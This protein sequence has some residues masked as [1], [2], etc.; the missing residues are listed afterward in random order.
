M[1]KTSRNM[2]IAAVVI[3]ALVIIGFVINTAKNKTND[4]SGTYYLENATEKQNIERLMSV[5]L[6]TDGSALLATPP[7]SSYLMP[8]CTYEVE[9]NILRITAVIE[10]NEEERFYGVKNNAVIARFV[11]TE[12]QTL[13]FE[14]S[15]VPIFA[16]AQAQYIY[17]P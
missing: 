10:T 6:N 15:T 7:I 9:D 12:D 5:T 4:Y 8:K 13:V 2:I 3:V 11:I 16:D 1:N 17:K 14:S